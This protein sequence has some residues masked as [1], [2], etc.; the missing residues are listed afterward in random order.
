MCLFFFILYLL[1]IFFSLKLQKLQPQYMRSAKMEKKIKLVSGNMNENQSL[2]L[3]TVSGIH[4]VSWNV[5]PT[6]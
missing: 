2:V 4:W 5:S 3:A 6:N 1:E